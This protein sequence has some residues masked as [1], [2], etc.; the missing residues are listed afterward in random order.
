MEPEKGAEYLS[1]KVEE[2]SYSVDN[3]YD[4]FYRPDIVAAKLRGEDISGLITITMKDAIKSP[5]PL[6]YYFS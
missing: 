2:I 5:P 1:V 6:R 4:V 3:F